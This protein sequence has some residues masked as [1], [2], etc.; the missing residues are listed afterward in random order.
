MT[1]YKENRVKIISFEEDFLVQVFNW[2]RDPPHWMA[3]P[4]TDELPS[5]CHVVRVT[6]CW[7]RRCLEA[8]VASKEFPVCPS[9]DIPERLTGMVDMR[10]VQFAIQPESLAAS[11]LGMIDVD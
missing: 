11:E 1:P 8:L 3:L 9:G 4:V 7:E 6:A 5:D 2:W 10:V